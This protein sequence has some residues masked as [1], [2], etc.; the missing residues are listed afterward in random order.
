M[1]GGKKNTNNDSKKS[2]KVGKKAGKNPPILKVQLLHG[3]SVTMCDTKLQK[4]TDVSVALYPAL[5][6]RLIRP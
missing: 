3:D 2:S 4:F 1:K 6:T 5:S